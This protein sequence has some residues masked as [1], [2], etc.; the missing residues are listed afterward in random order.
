M[1]ASSMSFVG[2]YFISAKTSTS[3]DDSSIPTRDAMMNLVPKCRHAMI[4]RG[5]F[6]MMVITPTGRAVR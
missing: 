3:T 4:N 2:Q 1:Q 6:K 5:M